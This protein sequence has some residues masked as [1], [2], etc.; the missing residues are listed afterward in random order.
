MFVFLEL[1]CVPTYHFSFQS[2]QESTVDSTRIS[3]WYNDIPSVSSQ[4]RV[5]GASSHSH[6]GVGVLRHTA[7]GSC[8]EPRTRAD[9]PTPPL[10]LCFSSYLVSSSIRCIARRTEG[11]VDTRRTLSH[12]CR[13][14]C[15]FL[16]LLFIFEGLF[17]GD[18]L[19]R[20]FCVFGGWVGL[21]LVCNVF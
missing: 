2:C 6:C 9:F 20:C 15:C 17:G 12:A 7:D 11:A 14:C 1:S 5:Q 21:E 10:C 4:L 16:S 19:V 8:I 3:S 18:N 13:D